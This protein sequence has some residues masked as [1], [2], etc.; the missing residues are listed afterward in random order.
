MFLSTSDTA[1]P[2]CLTCMGKNVYYIIFV[3][4]TGGGASHKEVI[5][6]RKLN[7]QLNEENNLLKIKV[8][9]LLDMVC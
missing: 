8:E 7:Q 2:R 6:L 5:K 1:N 4:E 9:L 3:A